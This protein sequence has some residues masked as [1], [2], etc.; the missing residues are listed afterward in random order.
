MYS[1]S[2]EFTNCKNQNI[3]LLTQKIVSC[4]PEHKVTEVLIKPQ[5]L[6]TDN[7]FAVKCSFL[8]VDAPSTVQ[9]TRIPYARFIVSNI[10]IIP[11]YNTPM[12][13]E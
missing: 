12:L 6:P 10:T 4:F 1:F 5:M 3:Q 11:E 13:N 2:N 8:F 7:S 9:H